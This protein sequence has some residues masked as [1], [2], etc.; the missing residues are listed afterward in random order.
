MR[1]DKIR[2]FMARD[3]RV[4]L[5]NLSKVVDGDT[6]V[7]SYTVF[8]KNFNDDTIP[9]VKYHKTRKTMIIYEELKRYNNNVYTSF[10]E[11][12]KEN[13]LKILKVERRYLDDICVACGAYVAEGSHICNN[14]IR[15]A[16][17]K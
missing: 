17:E 12:A 2:F 3:T 16:Y 5:D 8:R 13:G 6:V 4:I 9:A 15:D 11:W 14:C 7:I 10:I 1:I